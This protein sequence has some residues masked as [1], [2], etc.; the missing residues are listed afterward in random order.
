MADDW[1][2]RRT[3]GK[4]AQKRLRE[5]EARRSKPI[6]Q[7]GDKAFRGECPT[8]SHPFVVC[9]PLDKNSAATE[10]MPPLVGDVLEC[11]ACGNIARVDQVVGHTVKASAIQTPG[12]GRLLS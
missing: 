11:D 8:C 12:L 5:A 10:T 4:L 3:F 1:R 2:P 7:Q 9:H 6:P